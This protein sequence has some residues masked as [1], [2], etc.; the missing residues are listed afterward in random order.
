MNTLS[1]EARISRLVQT[2]TT[3]AG[4][5]E[6]R[7]LANLA[8]RRSV[9]TGQSHAYVCYLRRLEREIVA[10]RR[11]LVANNVEQARE[12]RDSCESR[13]AAYQFGP[14][15]PLPQALD[16]IARE[17]GVLP[18]PPMETEVVTIDLT[19]AR[20]CHSHEPAV[21]EAARRCHAARRAAGLPN[22]EIA[23]K[24]AL[25]ELTGKFTVSRTEWTVSDYNE[26]A[27]EINAGCYVVTGESSWQRVLF[28]ERRSVGTEQARE[29][30]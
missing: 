23:M 21:I 24:A 16:T 9:G 28:R 25:M 1:R 17:E 30:A 26:L 22:D 10:L 18:E 8:E 3:D 2:L 15:A 6:L 4:L 19:P 29:A 7:V 13:I 11:A 12:C 14:V 5:N 20:P 27:K